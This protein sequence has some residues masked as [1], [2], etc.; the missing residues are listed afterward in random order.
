MG[1]VIINQ[2]KTNT[3]VITLPA[4]GDVDWASKVREAF[5]NICDH[6]HTGGIKGKKITGDALAENTITINNIDLSSVNLN[7]FLNVQEGTEI[8]SGSVLLWSEENQEWYPSTIQNVNSSSNV[9]V[10]TNDTDLNGYDPTPGDILYVD[11]QGQSNP[12]T[13]GVNGAADFSHYNKNL[14][15]VKII[16]NFIP[17]VMAR[18]D[19]CKIMC[20]NDVTLSTSVNNSEVRSSQH[21]T[22][23]SHFTNSQANSGGY[24]IILDGCI[25]QN[26]SLQGLQLQDTSTTNSI[27]YSQGFFHKINLTSASTTIA[28]NSKIEAT[29][30]ILS[31]SGT[32]SFSGTTTKPVTIVNQ[33]VR[34]QVLPETATTNDILVWDGTEWVANTPSFKQVLSESGMSISANDFVMYN[35]S[36]DTLRI[37]DN[38]KIR[39]AEDFIIKGS[40]FYSH[41]F[42]YTFPLQTQGISGDNTG[43]HT[44]DLSG[45]TVTLDHIILNDPI[46]LNLANNY[47]KV[48]LKE[49]HIY[50]ND[51]TGGDNYS[52]ISYG[53]VGATE[54]S[55]D[56]VCERRTIIAPQN[57]H[58]PSLTSNTTNIAGP[59][60]TLGT[61]S[62]ETAHSEFYIDSYNASASRYVLKAY[63]PVEVTRGQISHTFRVHN[64]YDGPTNG[65]LE[66]A[67]LRVYLCFV[68]SSLVYKP[69]G[70]NDGL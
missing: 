29:E 61:V 8:P 11:S 46:T 51:G 64:A 60:V 19:E 47:Y 23:Q 13:N 7:T 6:D 52:A 25:V 9:Y 31:L 32:P 50:M 42:Y 16:S 37:V 10:I 21:I 34:T 55:D 53:N 1:D 68:E 5:Q 20:S 39:I 44:L 38:K 4:K 30:G 49:V 69:N 67:Y 58:I 3:L 62:N 59:R 36:D 45:N 27:N 14:K 41:L 33:E 35:T 63:K 26:S 40:L 15:G 54:N 66:G 22:I 2:G 65:Y 43:I 28:T 48:Y 70:T 24:N 17:L 56:Y 57:T 18:L 12:F